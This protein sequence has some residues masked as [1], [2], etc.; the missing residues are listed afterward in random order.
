VER[1]RSGVG[2]HPGADDGL[3]DELVEDMLVAEGIAEQRDG[4]SRRD[5]FGQVHGVVGKGDVEVALEPPQRQV[6]G[7]VNFTDGGVVR[8]NGLGRHGRELDPHVSR[9]NHE[10]LLPAGHSARR[11]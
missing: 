3:F 9:R 7:F 4:A 2:D 5:R 6:M 8:R 11:Q 1:G 10:V